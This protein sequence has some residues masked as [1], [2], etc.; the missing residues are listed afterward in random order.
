P[1]R[2]LFVSIEDERP[3]D[4]AAGNELAHVAHGGTVPEGQADFRLDALATSEVSRAKG[5]AE[6]V[7]DRFLAQ[8]VLAGFERS[9]GQ[10]EMGMARR[11]HV[12]EV[13]VVALDELASVRERQR[14]LELARRFA[15]TVDQRVGDGDNAAAGIAAVPGQVGRSCPRAGTKHADANKVVRLHRDTTINLTGANVT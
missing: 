9:P 11:A 10:L 12:D 4:E 15:R 5:I 1:L 6:V 13:D 14:D 2:V 8:H 3:A 7:G